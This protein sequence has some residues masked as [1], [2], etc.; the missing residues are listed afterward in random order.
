MNFKSQGLIIS[1]IILIALMLICHTVNYLYP[2]DSNY[3]INNINSI[4]NYNNMLNSFSNLPLSTPKKTISSE[5]IKLYYEKQNGQNNN[6]DKSICSQKNEAAIPCNAV[7]TCSLPKPTEYQLSN[8][9]IG[10]IYSDAY[11]NAGRELLLRTLKEP[12]A[13]IKTFR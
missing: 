1:I 11:K 2:S 3:K 12:K 5:Y 7:S 8:N 10:L 4:N 9:D 6:S 13:T